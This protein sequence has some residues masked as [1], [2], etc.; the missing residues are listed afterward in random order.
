MAINL[1]NEIMKVALSVIGK[2]HNFD[3]ARELHARDALACIYS[4]YP[5]F[6]LKGEQLPE[7]LV[8]THSWLH[9]SYMAY[10]WKQHTSESV[11]QL[12]RHWAAVDFGRYVARNLVDCDVYM[13]L[14]GSTLA[15]G[16]VAQRRGARYVCDRGSTHIRF[17]DQILHEENAKWGVHTK[18]VDSRTIA[19]EEAEYAQADLITVPSNFVRRTFVEQGVPENKLRVLPYGV[20]LTRFTPA[21]QPDEGRFDI[22]FVGGMSLRK[23]V[24][25]LVQAYSKLSHPAK[26]LTFVGAPSLIVM[27]LLKARGLWPEDAKVLGHIP[28]EELKHLMSKSHVLVLPSIEEGLAL[29]QAQAMACGCPVIGTPNAGS[30]NLFTDGVEGFIVKAGDVNALHDKLAHL[31]SDTALQLAMRQKSVLKIRD[32]GGWKQYGQ[33]VMVALTEEVK[34]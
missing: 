18:P 6:K 28:Q 7:S 24:Q 12:W 16:K 27:D 22:L 17:Q 33:A 32:I 29:V 5:K 20:N 4:G 26:S 11:M 15:A 34:K 25:Y 3:L 14:S 23:G 19:I 2:F 21:G 8:H 13:G 30:E 1:Q 10:P 9:G 31:A